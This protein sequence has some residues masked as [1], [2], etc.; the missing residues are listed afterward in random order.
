MVR[1]ILILINGADSER[2]IQRA[3]KF[4]PILGFRSNL[5]FLNSVNISLPLPTEFIPIGDPSWSA[6]FGHPVFEK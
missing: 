4:G 6:N 5:F 3:I 1:D 2:A